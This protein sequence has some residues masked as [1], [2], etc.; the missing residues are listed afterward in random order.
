MYRFKK[1]KYNELMNGRMAMWL[2]EQIG[3]NVSTVSRIFNGRLCKRALAIAIV[4]TMD[5]NHDVEYF[6]DKIDDKGE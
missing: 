5:S 3:Y 1:E 2:A 4:K 6:F